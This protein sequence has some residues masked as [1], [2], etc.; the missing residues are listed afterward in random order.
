M[1]ATLKKIAVVSHILPPSQSGQAMVLYRLLSRL[2]AESYHLL[3]RT[4]YSDQDGHE[5]A[6]PPLP[7]AY[8]H[9][10]SLTEAGVERALSRLLLR[11]INPEKQTPKGAP[12]FA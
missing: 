4:D 5:S 11:N 3:S 7:G 8:H 6:F 2:P 1:S 9:L 12:G 10:E